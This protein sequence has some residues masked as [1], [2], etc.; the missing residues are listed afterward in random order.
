MV[1]RPQAG[2]GKRAPQVEHAATADA[3]CPAVRPCAVEG[4]RSITAHVHRTAVAKLGVGGQ[5]ATGDDQRF[6]RLQASDRSCAGIQRDGGGTRD[7]NRHIVSR[8]RER[9]RAPVGRSVPVEVAA[10]AV[11]R[12]GAE[13]NA[14]LAHIRRNAPVDSPVAAASHSSGDEL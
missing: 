4:Q 2:R 1:H 13:K 3:Q 8:F 9:V 5:R 12:D 11:P 6:V 14:G 10:A 7:V